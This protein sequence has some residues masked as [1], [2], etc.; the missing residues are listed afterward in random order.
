MWLTL[1]VVVCTHTN[2]HLYHRLELYE[3]DMF[4]W[5]LEMTVENLC[6]TTRTRKGSLTVPLT[7]SL[8]P[9]MT[10]TKFLRH[11]TRR[12]SIFFFNLQYSRVFLSDTSILEEFTTQPYVWYDILGYGC[13]IVE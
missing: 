8:N 9:K 5:D 7:P 2:L 3:S 1:K 6:K 4:P 10:L 12:V 11:V 13:E